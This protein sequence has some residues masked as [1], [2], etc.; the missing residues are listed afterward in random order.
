MPGTRPA[1]PWSVFNVDGVEVPY[2]VIPFD[3]EGVCTAPATRRHLVDAAG[4]GVTDIYLFSHGW[5]NDW[6]VVEPGGMYDRFIDGFLD[7]TRRHGRPRPGA[8]P[9]LV[10]VFWPSIV[11]SSDTG[12][13]MAAGGTVDRAAELAHL[14]AVS[15]V[16]AEAVTAADRPRFYELIALDRLD[17]AELR[18]LADLM[19][20]L[21]QDGDDEEATGAPTPDGVVR[22]ADELVGLWRE[23]GS[24][25]ARDAGPTVVTGLPPE[26]NDAPVGD[27]ADRP[28]AAGLFSALDPRQVVRL[29]TVLIMKDRAGRVGANGVQAMLHELL[30]GSGDARV[31]MVGHSYGCKVMLSA[32]AAAAPPRNV[33]SVL[34]MQPAMSYLA[35]A[36]RLPGSGGTGGYRSARE[37]CELPIMATFTK[38]DVPLRR[39][40][41]LAVRRASDLGEQDIGVAGRD[42]P[43]SRFAAMGGWGPGGLGGHVHD[44]V[45][46]RPADGPYDNP[47]QPGDVVALEAHDQI[48]GHGDIVKDVTWWA[49][50][51]LVAMD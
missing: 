32:L 21:Y 3:K 37:R 36:D 25:A 5:N 16:A 2:Y 28:E 42:V 14:D 23:V 35:L 51:N 6:S 44:V 24:A 49:L 27:A 33:R 26:P 38:K 50:Y 45:I 11:L 8:R 19:L 7:L 29:A 1:G 48:D 9:L 10:G 47:D 17:D 22:D 30:D 43:R 39:L 18:E 46:K 12:P 13:R 34:L 4:A 15:E 41:H 40:F 31:H 20:P